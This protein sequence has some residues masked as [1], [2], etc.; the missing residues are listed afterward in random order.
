MHTMDKKIEAEIL[1]NTIT[2]QVTQQVKC[3]LNSSVTGVRNLSLQLKWFRGYL[4]QTINHIKPK[5]T[6][7]LQCHLNF[8]DY[9][10]CLACTMEK[11]RICVEAF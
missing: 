4:I 11:R 5:I 1:I 9:E 8:E 10:P 2:K 3:V 6:N 7:K